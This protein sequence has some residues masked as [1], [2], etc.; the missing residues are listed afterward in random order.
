M[1][2]PTPQSRAPLLRGVGSIS[3]QTLFN[4]NL[5]SINERPS[6]F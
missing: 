5:V 1:I 4:C 6:K 2:K 3:F